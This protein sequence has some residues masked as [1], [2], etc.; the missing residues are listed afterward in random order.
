MYVPRENGIPFD[1]TT[2]PTRSNKS[3]EHLR[4]SAATR[5]RSLLVRDSLLLSA[6]LTR[7]S[8]RRSAPEDLFSLQELE[9]AD[10]A[11]LHCALLNEGGGRLITAPRKVDP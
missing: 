11:P 8:H 3:P 9:S 10:R 4:D 5:H 6:R 2:F 7:K 1:F